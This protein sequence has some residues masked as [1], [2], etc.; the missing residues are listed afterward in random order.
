MYLVARE[1]YSIAAG[2]RLSHT[3]KAYYYLAKT[4]FDVPLS[5]LRLE[6]CQA[7][8]NAV[9]RVTLGNSFE[10]QTRPVKVAMKLVAQAPE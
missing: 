5:T 9:R 6:V 4:E 2:G 7:K 1:S 8:P 3:P 10:V